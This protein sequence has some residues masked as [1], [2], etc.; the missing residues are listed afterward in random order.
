MTADG[1]LQTLTRKAL[2][3]AMPSKALIAAGSL[4]MALA[5]T[6]THGDEDPAA[7]PVDAWKVIQQV[8][9]AAAA[10]D[11][12]QL[13]SL[14]ADDFTYSFGGDGS[15][16]Q[17]I[18]AWKKSPAKYLTELQR[19]LTK[20]CHRSDRYYDGQ[21]HVY[22]LGKTD[23]GFRAGFTLAKDGWKMRYFVEGD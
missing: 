6:P 4:T 8:D 5:A 7:L 11:W 19:V 21:E 1:N 14:I 17:A 15:A 10:Q 9:R 22:C 12:G 2:G 13:R 3:L 18:A 20:A 16:D 23:M